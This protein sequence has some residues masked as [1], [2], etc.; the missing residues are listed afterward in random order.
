MKALSQILFEISCTQDIQILFS[1]GH[2]SEKGHSSDMKKIRVNYF[3]MRNTYMKFQIPSIHRS[4]VSKFL[5]KWKNQ[6]NFQN[7]IFLS[8][9]DREFSKVDQVI[10]SSAPTSMPNM[11]ALAQILF[12]I[13]CTQDFQIL[14][15]KGHNSEKGHNSDMKKNTGQLFF[16]EE[17]III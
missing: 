1:K 10:Y 11:K 6:S 17:Y 12:E 8:K 5:E 15:S 4:K 2:N 9:F 13:S 14:F 7:S 3:F 16:H